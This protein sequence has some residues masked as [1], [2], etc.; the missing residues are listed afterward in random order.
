MF[1]VWNKSVLTTLV[2]IF[3]ISL[4]ILGYSKIFDFKK[5][6]LIF[7]FFS[8]QFFRNPHRNIL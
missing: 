2:L 5:F 1:N 6:C 3:P 8:L 4:C 7:Y